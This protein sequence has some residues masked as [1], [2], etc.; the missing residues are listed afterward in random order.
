MAK[1][2][3]KGKGRQGKVKKCSQVYS[4]RN[5]RFTKVD[6]KTGKFIDQTSHRGKAFKGVRVK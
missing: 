1:N 5:K 2:G 3:P 6:N 4:K